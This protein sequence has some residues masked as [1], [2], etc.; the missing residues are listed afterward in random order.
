MAI[1]NAM[2]QELLTADHSSSVKINEQLRFTNKQWETLEN[3]TYTRDKIL[4]TAKEI[5]VFNRDASE[6]KERILVILIFS[7]FDSTYKCDQSQENRI[8]VHITI[9]VDTY[10][11]V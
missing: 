8:H 10:R 5:H 4:A 3:K 2:G 11:M 7:I 1:L 9:T 6:A